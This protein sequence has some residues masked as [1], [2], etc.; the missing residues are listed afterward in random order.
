[1]Y[2]AMTKPA[3]VTPDKVFHS[4]HNIQNAFVGAQSGPLNSTVVR[5]DA[6]TYLLQE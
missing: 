1:M 6:H 5:E 4:Y 2:C 3:G